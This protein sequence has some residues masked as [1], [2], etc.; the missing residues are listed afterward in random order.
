ME[1]AIVDIETTGS[2]AGDNGMTEIA[3]IIH[4]GQHVVDKFQSLINPD[5]PIPFHIQSLTGISNEMVEDAPTF[6]QI[7][8]KV[9]ALLHKRI[10][11]AHNVNFDYSFLSKELKKAG[12]DWKSQKLCTVRLSR[13]IFPNLAS[14]SLGKLC[15]NLE[16]PIYQRH[17]AMGDAEATVTLFEMLLRNDHDAVVPTTLKKTKEQ[18]LPTHINQEDFFNLPESP[19]IYLFRNRSNKII[20]IGKA[21]NIKKRVLSHFSGNNTSQKRQSFINDIFSIDFEESGTEL[22]AL[23][24]EC[25][26]IKEHWPIHNRALKKFEPKFG[27]FEYEDQKGYRRLL[28]STFNKEAKAIQY[29]ERATEANHLMLKLITE[30]GLNNKLCTFCT[31]R[32]ELKSNIDYTNLLPPSS[33][34]E[35][36]NAALEYVNS[37]RNSFI[38]IDQG[39]N[40]EEKS[41]IF[42]SDDQLYAFGFIHTDSQINDPSDIISEQDKCVSNYYMNAL[43]L[44]YAERFP[45]KVKQKKTFF[46]K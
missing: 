24:M 4:N 41:Y 35:M 23:L 20:Y 1:Y 43:V 26:M 27:L 30:F 42:F 13:K 21:I 3:I 39:R 19:G 34:N 25:K 36:V 45:G 16:I 33:Y 28:V 9:H 12:Y 5:T 22:M 15:Q 40:L 17:R 8:K 46:S 18:Q 38:I 6:K 11:V 2:Y 7:A 44:Q 32:P 29:F 10:F 31:I 37:N 14:Y